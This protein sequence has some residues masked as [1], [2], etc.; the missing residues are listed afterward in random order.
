[1]PTLEN[2][3]LRATFRNEG[4]ELTGLTYLPQ[5]RQYLWWG[6]PAVWARHAPL[7]FPIV[8]RLR[9]NRYRYDGQTY[10]LPQHGFARDQRFELTDHTSDQ[11]TFELVS[12]PTTRANY[13]FAFVL[14]VT[15]R[16]AGSRLRVGYEVKNTDPDPLWFSIGGH[17]AFA[18]KPGE[19]LADYR[20]AF[21]RR[22]TARRYL[23]T[24]GLFDGRTAPVLTDAD[25]LPLDERTFAEDALVFKNLDSEWV[26]LCNRAGDHRVA[27]H[28]AGFP[29]LGVWSRSATAG[30]V[31][32]EPWHGL[33]DHQQA[34]GELT[35][36][37][38]IRTLAAGQ[39]FR[40]HYHLEVGPEGRA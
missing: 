1:M 31:C 25:V 6:D 21:Q 22:E 20:L 9:D 30:F 24:D 37:E 28:F 36:K 33:S 7:L 17:P 11:L 2:D 40:C 26:A 13:P 4:A 27:L 18:L 5:D 10:T 34:G 16:L 15:Y 19:T 14:R 8:G 38:G 39:V 12:D 32:L 35:E 3:L 29:F 23:L